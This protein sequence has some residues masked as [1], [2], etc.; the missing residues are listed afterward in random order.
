VISV[1]TKLIVSRYCDK[2]IGGNR[3]N[4]GIEVPVKVSWLLADHYLVSDLE[5]GGI[6]E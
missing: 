4:G 1:W 5:I 3:P 6:L 2:K